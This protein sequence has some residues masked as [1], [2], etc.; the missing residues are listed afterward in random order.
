MT[1]EERL[2]GIKKEKELLKEEEAVKHDKEE[3]EYLESLNKLDALSQRIK[4]ILKIAN[5]CIDNE[6]DLPYPASKYGYHQDDCLYT[7]KISGFISNGWSH[8]VG[9]MRRNKKAYFQYLGFYCGG[10]CGCY[11]FYTNGNEAFDF[12]ENNN[13][14]NV[15]QHQKERPSKKHIDRF[16]KEFPHFEECFYKWVDSLGKRD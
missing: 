4:D 15:Q 3:L 16:V 8:W 2:K 10:A 7:E 6:I 1:L 11:D 9:F 5:A 13:I 12:Y 14:N